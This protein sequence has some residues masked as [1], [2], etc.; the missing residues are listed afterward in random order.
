MEENRICYKC[1]KEYP[2]TRE[3]FYFKNKKRGWLSSLCISCQKKRNN[4]I[5]KKRNKGIRKRVIY[6]EYG[7][8]FCSICNKEL[9]ATREYFHKKKGGKFGLRENCIECLKEYDAKRYPIIKEHQKEI[10]QIYLS[11][12]K[13]RESERGR[14]YRKVHKEQLIKYRKEYYQKNK[15]KFKSWHKAYLKTEN[16]REIIRFHK[17]ANT[18]WRRKI[19]K[20]IEK[21][22]TP[23]DWKRCLEYF[24]NKCAY[25]GTNKSEITIDHLIPIKEFGGTIKSNIVPACRSCNSSKNKYD[26]NEWYKKQVFYDENK[27]QNINNYIMI[28][29]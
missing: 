10:R 4:E 6:T 29:A 15:D 12:N 3:Y 19:G 13:E 26:F 17:K 9:P 28:G 2:N 18:Q 23:Q 27:K 11:E 24:D 25:C 16:G 14:K 7:T 21:D 1:K 20:S 22:F 8:K 5:N